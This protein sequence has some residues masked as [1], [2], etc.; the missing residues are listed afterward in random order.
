MEISNMVEED[1]IVLEEWT[2]P[3]FGDNVQQIRYYPESNEIRW[4][5][6]DPQ[7]VNWCHFRSGEVGTFWLP[8]NEPP[9]FT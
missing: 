3:T 5:Y 7:R 6:G 2:S 8:I 1:Y 9:L 4:Y